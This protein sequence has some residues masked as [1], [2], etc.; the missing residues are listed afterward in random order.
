MPHTPT[1]T[2]SFTPLPDF[3]TAPFSSQG[4]VTPDTGTFTTI[5]SVSGPTTPTPN[6]RFDLTGRDGANLAAGIQGVGSL[7]N[8]F[9]AYQQFRLGK[10]TLAQ[11]RAAFNLNSANQ[12]RITNAAIEDRALRRAAQRSDLGS[13]FARI[14][15]A[16]DQ[17]VADR[18]VSGAPI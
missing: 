2:D 14:Q 17:V 5:P 7:A 15:E 4:I 1:H 8:A 18:R 10:D 16:A 3:T 12:A 13:D 9:A 11:N 6:T